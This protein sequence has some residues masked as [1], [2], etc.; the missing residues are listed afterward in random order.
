ME[1]Q[2]VNPKIGHVFVKKGVLRVADR[3]EKCILVQWD[4]IEKKFKTKRIK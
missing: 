2:I 3:Y 1:S 4:C